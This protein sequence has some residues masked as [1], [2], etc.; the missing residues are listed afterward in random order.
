MIERLRVEGFRMLRQVDVPLRPLTVLVGANN[1]GKTSFLRSLEFLVGGWTWQAHFA[2]RQ[3]SRVAVTLSASISGRGVVNECVAEPG[4]GGASRSG[5]W[6]L[7]QPEL[8]PRIYVELPRHGPPMAGNAVP[9][10]QGAPPLDGQGN[11]V[12][13]LLD[14]LQRRDR[15]RYDRYVTAARERIPGLVDVTLTATSSNMRALALR[16]EGGLDLDAEQASAGV[17]VML[18][19]LSLA[20]H[21]RPPRLIMVEEPETG[22]HPRRLKDVVGL[23]RSLTT[24]E[25]GGEP[26]QVILTTHSPYLLDHVDLARDQVL[27]FRRGGEGE[28]L[29]EAADPQRLNAFLDEFMLGEVWFNQ[30]EEGLVAPVADVVRPAPAGE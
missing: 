9:D 6:S 17:R 7:L 5:S 2:W 19:F 23:L 8:E 29:V 13:A 16:I 28:A 25:H 3:S 26:A 15:P 30:G 14:H 24:G 4:G 21:P 1:S 11:G 12:P 27:V 18:F 22:L 20:Y 10:V